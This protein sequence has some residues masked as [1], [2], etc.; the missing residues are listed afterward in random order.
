MIDQKHYET[1][2]KSARSGDPQATQEFFGKFSVRFLSLVTSELQ[3]YPI[4]KNSFDLDAK[5][6]EVCQK[7]V[8]VLKT[9][10]PI[11]SEQWSLKRAMSIMRNEVDDFIIKSLTDLAK[12]GNPAAENLLFKKIR[13]KLIRRMEVKNWSFSNGKLDNQ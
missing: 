6:Q 9:L 2:L 13:D 8:E 5:S 12:R 7:A 4:L 3:K 1:L 11:S 10:L